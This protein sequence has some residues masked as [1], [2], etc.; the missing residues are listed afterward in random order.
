MRFLV[1]GG[2]GFLGSHLVEALCADGGAVH[3]LD[4]LS[5]GERAHLEAAEAS[6]GRTGRLTFVQGDVR[7]RGLVKGLVGACDAVFHLAGAVGVA[8]VADDPVGTW[9]RNVE[10]TAAVLDACARHARRCLV[11]STSEVYGHGA[12]GVLSED[13]PVRLEPSARREVYAVS[14]LAGESLAVALH[15]A[16]GLPVTVVRLFNVV[17]PRQASRYGMVLPRF[18]GAALRGE[19]L[20]VHGDG[21]QRRCFLHVHDAVAALRALLASPEAEGRIVNV[22]SD[23]EVSVL[24]LAHRVVEAAGTGASVVHVPFEAVYGAGFVDPPRRRPDLA[25]LFALTGLRPRR[26]LHDAVLDVIRA[27]G[28]PARASHLT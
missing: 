22:G 10:G 18:V 3:V 13:A 17:G 19:P 9:S 8:R 11:T 28:A 20:V 5:T 4:D 26:T 15:R 16:S 2:A 24:D 14:K 23:E 12:C 27:A 21:T 25:R 6:A 1:T 7:D